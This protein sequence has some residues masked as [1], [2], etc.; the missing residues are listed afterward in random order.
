MSI[1]IFGE[2]SPPAVG[3]AEGDCITLGGNAQLDY[4]ER[5]PRCKRRYA[6]HCRYRS[7]IG[8]E[9]A[10]KGKVG[11][12]LQMLATMP[13][14]VTQYDTYPWHTRLGASIHLLRE[15]GL[16]IETTREGEWRHGRYRLIT[17]G[18]LII[19]AETGEAGQ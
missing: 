5:G 4:S 16:A 10:H 12:V 6:S 1:P 13:G 11:R 15:S 3:A 8:Q 7:D 17:P 9:F 19:Q 2:V 14:G 18:C